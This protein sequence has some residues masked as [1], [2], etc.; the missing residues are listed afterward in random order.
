MQQEKYTREQKPSWNKFLERKEEIF[1]N[2]ETTH[3]TLGNNREHYREQEKYDQ[4]QKH[5]RN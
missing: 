2:K 4:E 3:Y 5:L 1:M